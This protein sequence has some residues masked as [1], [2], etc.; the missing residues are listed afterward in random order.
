MSNPNNLFPITS[1]VTADHRKEQFRQNPKVIWFTGLSGSGKSTL[2]TELEYRLFQSQ[3]KTYLLDADSIR[4]GLNS[5]LG[6]QDADRREN[7]RRVAEVCKLFLDAGLIVIT[8]FITPFARDRA[9]IKRLIGETRVI[10]IFVDCPLE[11]CEQRDVKGLY[12]R[13]RSGQLKNFTGI[14][15]P[16]EPPVNSDLTIRSN[17]LTI[18]ESVDALETYI[19]PKVNN[20]VTTLSV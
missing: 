17:L 8:A 18:F 5:D 10:E 20:S 15:S 4:S 3:F 13:A 7:I 2:A 16:Y 11:I 6:F 1:L 9:A 14:H 19:L 12:K